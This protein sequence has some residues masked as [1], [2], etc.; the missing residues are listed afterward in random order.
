LVG[1]LLN[2]TALAFTI[3]FSGFLLLAVNWQALHSE[4]LVPHDPHI[5]CDLLA[6]ALHKQPWRE[7]SRGLVALVGLY[8]GLCCLYWLWSA[9]QV[10]K[11]IV[12]RDTQLRDRI[13]QASGPT[14]V[15]QLPEVL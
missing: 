14:G 7:H 3:C 4:C 5:S 11:S 13:G 12:V 10:R 2:L 6:V 15:L 9:A 8:L 1:R